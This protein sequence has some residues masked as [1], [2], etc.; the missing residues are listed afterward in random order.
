MALLGYG[1]K[2]L[3]SPAWP[4][5]LQ[6]TSDPTGLVTP[7]FIGQRYTDG[8]TMWDAVGLTSADWA[9]GGGGGVGTGDVVGPASATADHFA[10]Y[11]GT[12]GKL[13]KDSGV[14]SSDFAT[15]AQG[16][17][18]RTPTV[19]SSDKHSVAYLPLAGDTMT[20][21]MTA[22]SDTTTKHGGVRNIFL[23]TEAATDGTN[24]TLMVDGDLWV[25]H[26]A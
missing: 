7:D 3:A 13:I 11:N 15:A 8:T 14:G 20:G 2:I 12:T 16:T 25:K 22:V 10:S 23:S 1:Q 17:D 21:V 18:A 4:A 24:A 6:G 26:A 19:H 9:S 5:I